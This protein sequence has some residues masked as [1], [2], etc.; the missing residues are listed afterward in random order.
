MM[1]LNFKIF[2]FR[3]KKIKILVILALSLMLYGPKDFERGQVEKTLIWKKFK[4]GIFFH[5]CVLKRNF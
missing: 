2:C 5:F 1:Q 3:G 4:V